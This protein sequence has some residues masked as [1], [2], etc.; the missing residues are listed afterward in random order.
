MGDQ[1]PWV[2][3]QTMKRV[4]EVLVSLRR[5]IRATDIH[6]K[7]LSK[8]SGLTS[9]QLLILMA[10]S[11]LGDVTIGTVAKDV[12][13]SQATVTTI[14]DRLEKRDLVRRVRSEVDRRRVHAQLTEEGQKVVED[15]PS[16]LQ[17]SFVEQFD[18]LPEWEQTMLLSSVQKLAELMQASDID[19]SP[20]LYVGD[21]THHYTGSQGR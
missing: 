21:V 19:A 20:V 6:S 13:L 9:P 12:N 4:D 7:Q 17:E 10:I 15:A 2:K 8:H 5:I 1:T 3:D 11:K 16:P 18:K 14:L